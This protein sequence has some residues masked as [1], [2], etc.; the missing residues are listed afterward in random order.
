MELIGKLGFLTCFIMIAGLYLFLQGCGV[1]LPPKFLQRKVSAIVLGVLLL[2][3]SVPHAV[4][5]ATSAPIGEVILSSIKETI[6]PPVAIDDKAMIE[7]VFLE[8]TDKIVYDISLTVQ[9]DEARKLSDGMKHEIK[10]Q[11]CQKQD[12]GFALKMGVSVEV[13]FRDLAGEKLEPIIIR[14]VDCVSEEMRIKAG[15]LGGGE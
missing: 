10:S 5:V 12:F 8:G 11:A 1:K 3:F 15:Q 7:N 2:F 14:P 9:A 6:R 13:R 4:I